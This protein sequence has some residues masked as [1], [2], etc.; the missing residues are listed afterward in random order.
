[1]LPPNSEQPGWVQRT[2]HK[3]FVWHTTFCGRDTTRRLYTKWEFWKKSP[4]PPTLFIITVINSVC[5]SCCSSSDIT[6]PPPRQVC[7]RKKGSRPLPSLYNQL[8]QRILLRVSVSCFSRSQERN[9]ECP[10]PRCLAGSRRTTPDVRRVMVWERNSRRAVT[11]KENRNGSQPLS[12][13]LAGAQRHSSFTLEKYSHSTAS[14]E[15]VIISVHW[16]G[17]VDCLDTFIS[18][19]QQR[20]QWTNLVK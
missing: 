18:L 10:V 13:L 20:S 12:W 3:P 11:S 9:A 14:S 6:P 4:K 5:T 2:T 16:V 8:A 17:N 7:G 1:M 15:V 19:S